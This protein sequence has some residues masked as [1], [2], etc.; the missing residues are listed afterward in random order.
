MPVEL[1]TQVIGMKEFWI[2]IAMLLGLL[3][4]LAKRRE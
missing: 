1:F 2:A 4:V 3:T